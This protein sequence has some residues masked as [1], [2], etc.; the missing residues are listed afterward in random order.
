MRETELAINKDYIRKKIRNGE[1]LNGRDMEEFRDIEIDAG[2]VRETAD[3]SALVKMGDTKL[4]VGIT[5][6][7]GEPYDDA[8][9]AGTLIT[10]AELVPLAK[11]EYEAGP[12]RAD[13]V[14]IARVVDRGLR[15]SGILDLED[16]GIEDGE[17]CWLL[18]IDVH[19]LDY[20][21][22]L[23]DAAFLG[24][25]TALMNGHFPAY[26]DE[27]DELD[28]DEDGDELPVDGF[29]VTLT[30]KKIADQ[31]LLDTTGEE[32][33]VLDARLTVTLDEDDN[34]VSLQKG[35][36]GTMSHEDVMKI[37]RLT[38]DHAEMLRDKV[39]EALDEA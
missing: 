19:V 32:E 23:I 24:A 10:N 35:E 4:L 27:E 9:E 31:L 26:D 38:E 13:A 6:D 29:P 1:R 15:E 3:G 39:E 36:P 22:N 28:R 30:G 33:D 16:L 11:E 21:G 17:K 20:D 7:L 14:E 5:A 2:Y 37:T 34:V 12:P 25:V 18:F 8:P